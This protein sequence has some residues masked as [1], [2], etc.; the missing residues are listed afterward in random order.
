MSDAALQRIAAL[1]AEQKFA[2]LCTSA[3]GWPYA[4][5]VAFAAEDDA[6]RIYF[7]TPENTQKTANLRADGRVALLVDNRSNRAQD[8][9]EAMAATILGQAEL[10]SAQTPSEAKTLLV[11]KHPD[12][13]P[14]FDTENTVIVCIH[15]Q[16]CRLVDHFQTTTDIRF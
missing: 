16:R 13:N 10:L 2:V 14:F 12:L 11:R 8:C 6:K 15:V 1:L 5:L 9:Q 4:G 7:A 3:D